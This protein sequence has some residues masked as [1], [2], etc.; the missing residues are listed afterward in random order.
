MG[1]F[2]PNLRKLIS[3]LAGVTVSYAGFGVA[4]VPVFTASGVPE[5]PALVSVVGGGVILLLGL[6]VLAYRPERPVRWGW[7]RELLMRALSRKKTLP[8]ICRRHITTRAQG[9]VLG[10]QVASEAIASCKDI[11]EALSPALTEVTLEEDAGLFELGEHMAHAS[12]VVSFLAAIESRE[13]VRNLEVI[14]RH[15]EDGIPVRAAS[16]Q[17]D[18]GK[19][20]DGVDECV[21][22]PLRSLHQKLATEYAV[23]KKNSKRTNET[24]AEAR[25]RIKDALENSQ[26]WLKYF[27]NKFEPNMETC[28]VELSN[29]MREA[30][31]GDQ[32]QA[33]FR[34][35]CAPLTLDTGARS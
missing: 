31:D 15:G 4:V 30:W 22:S 12:G 17:A 14:G 5:M 24:S 10:C 32:R 34:P 35:G 28:A 2:K 27:H 6:A 9:T 7:D 20:K 33:S 3:N 18:L 13:F 29:L 21:L 19:L 25:A 11:Q 23:R 16:I 26:V 1:G 8:L